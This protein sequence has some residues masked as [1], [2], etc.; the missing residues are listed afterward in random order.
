MLQRAVELPLL[1]PRI[2]IPHFLCNSFRLK[3][4]K[5][6]NLLSYPSDSRNGLI[7]S[8]TSSTFFLVRGSVSACISRDDMSYSGAILDAST[9]TGV[10]DFFEAVLVSSNGDTILC[11]VFRLGFSLML[12]S[13]SFAGSLEVGFCTYRF[14]CIRQPEFIEPRD[15]RRPCVQRRVILCA[16]TVFGLIYTTKKQSN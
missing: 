4:C 16:R 12:E 11:F 9:H 2:L 10:A 13:L 1:L 15:M 3:T 8:S 6:E 14:C 5:T 7:S